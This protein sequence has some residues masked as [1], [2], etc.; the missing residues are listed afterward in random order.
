MGHS[1]RKFLRA[2]AL[3]L[4]SL[5]LF[6]GLGRISTAF[7]A[8]ADLP[9]VKPDDS[10]AKS[11]SFCLDAD[12]PTAQCAVRKS[13]DKKDQ[14]C[15]GCQLYTKVKGEGKKE[16]GKCLV[17]STGLVPANGWCNSWVK[18]PT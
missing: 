11:L 17:M 2:A 16:L 12:K 10:T 14:Y 9:P 4:A 7:G 18:R 5:P 3:S 8:D 1:R 6:A 13:K 15:R